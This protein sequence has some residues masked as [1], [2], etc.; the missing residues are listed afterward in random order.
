MKLWEFL[1]ESMEKYGDKTAF[2]KNNISYN[3][4]IINIESNKKRY[5]NR[6]K[7]AFSLSKQNQAIKILNILASENVA[8]PVS[9]C[10]GLDLMREIENEIKC[11][12]NTYPQLAFIMFTSGTT[13]KPKGVMLS[14]NNIIEN[15]KAIDKY[16]KVDSTDKILI[17]RPLVHIAVLT[18]E[19]LYGL[20]KGLT[21]DFY[22][23]EFNAKRLAKYIDE[24]GITVF[25]T[26]PTMI[27][28]LSKYLSGTSLKTVVLS[29]ERLTE[30]IANILREKFPAINF[31]NVY[32]L[33]ENSPRVSALTP[34]NFFEKIGSIGK[35][36]FNTYLEIKNG[37][38]LVNSRSVMQGYYRNYD[39]TVN[40][41]KNG[42]LHTGDM[43]RCDDEGFYYILGRK[44][45]M[46]IRS[47]LNIYPQEVENII[48]KYEGVENCVA[49]G[50]EEINYGQKICLKV[51]GNID[52]KKLREF[53]INNLP[54]HLVPSKIEKVDYIEMTPSGK[55]KRR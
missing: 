39:L 6:L 46:I 8:V 51:K 41:I 21:I 13:G 27:Y 44:D 47:G 18:G 5:K 54:P 29:G 38:L 26:T 53:L 28:H 20:Y 17:A 42:W 33:T 9:D 7:T 12:K 49:Y 50:E 48:R 4:L 25:C 19:L 23:E 2:L 31:Y 1:K 55:V 15:I 45:E 34:D 36:L 14:D 24:N 16:F 3:N 35:P 32:G 43:A 10:Y 11:D 40:K 37:E 22:E 30:N 52:V